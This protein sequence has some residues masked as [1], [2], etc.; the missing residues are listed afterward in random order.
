VIVNLLN[1]IVTRPSLKTL[2]DED[3]V[4]MYI[5][6][7]NVNYFNLLYDRY[8]D[9]IYSKC[10]SMLRDDEMAED[11]TQEIFVKILLSLS[12]FSGRSK[13]STWVYSITY[14][15]CIDFIRKGKKEATSILEEGRLDV[16]DDS[17]YDN[18]IAE[19]SVSRLQDVLDDLITEDKSILMM[20]YQDDLSIKDISEVLDKSE[21]A[22]KMQI[23]RAKERFL[24][25]YKSRYADEFAFS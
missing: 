6:S 8:T 2:S 22:I 4:T 13:F 20:K 14:N 5:E 24:K 1:P 12:K 9:K 21:S 18:E 15:Y 10:M 23:L 7:Q 11:A 19:V 25:I 16:E 3:A 17:A